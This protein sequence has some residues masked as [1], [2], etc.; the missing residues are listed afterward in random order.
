MIVRGSDGF[1]E[2]NG[3][4]E[5]CFV[6]SVAARRVVVLYGA[7][8]MLTA[9]VKPSIYLPGDNIDNADCNLLP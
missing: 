6:W 9:G 3:Y 4:E 5:L 2:G 8:A 1:V 7:G